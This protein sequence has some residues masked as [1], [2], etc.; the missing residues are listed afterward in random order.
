MLCNTHGHGIHERRNKTVL[1]NIAFSRVIIAERDIIIISDSIIH[2]YTDTY[3][4]Y[5]TSNSTR[6]SLVWPRLCNTV[7][8]YQGVRI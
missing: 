2:T 5:Y 4:A 6:E 1:E 3:V 7:Y 8:R